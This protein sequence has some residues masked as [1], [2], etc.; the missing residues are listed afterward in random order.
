MEEK[1]CPITLGRWQ[2]RESKI[3]YDSFP[4]IRVGEQITN[5]SNLK[6]K[7]IYDDLRNSRVDDYLPGPTKLPY[8]ATTKLYACSTYRLPQFP[9][10]Y[11]FLPRSTP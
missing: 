1:I 5:S 4:A 3:S 6:C 7:N 2:L 11:L 8:S 10:A 9:W